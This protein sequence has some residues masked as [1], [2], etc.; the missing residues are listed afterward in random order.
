M[1]D[2]YQ[3]SASISHHYASFIY[4]KEREK[5]LHDKNH[6][7]GTKNNNDTI[8]RIFEFKK[9][10]NLSKNIPIEEINGLM[11]ITTVLHSVNSSN[12]NGK[13]LFDKRI[14]Q[15]NLNELNRNISEIRFTNT[16][17]KNP[18]NLAD[19]LKR[20]ELKTVKFNTKIEHTT[21]EANTMQFVQ[22]E[23]YKHY[24]NTKNVQ[25]LLKYVKCDSTIDCVGDGENKKNYDALIQK[26]KNLENKRTD[27]DNNHNHHYE[28]KNLSLPH[29]YSPFQY[30]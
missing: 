10:Q 12:R 16:I 30:L 19:L 1:A 8:F 28:V 29:F 27:G 22:L 20:T 18:L 17:S 25:D 23:S 13:A 26:E 3:K 15:P 4:E 9:I 6:Y 2:K 14:K 24:Y 11:P 7:N 21:T 5:F